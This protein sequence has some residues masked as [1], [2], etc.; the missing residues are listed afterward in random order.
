MFFWGLV[1]ATEVA[2][3]VVMRIVAALLLLSL[4]LLPL[5]LRFLGLLRQSS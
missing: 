1:L 2:F 3:V 4:R 5:N